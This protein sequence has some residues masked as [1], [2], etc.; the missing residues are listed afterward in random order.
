LSHS[1]SPLMAFGFDFPPYLESH[2]HSW[3]YFGDF[4]LFLL[5]MV[6]I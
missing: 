3:F 1:S 5:Q 6:L 4:L 2:L